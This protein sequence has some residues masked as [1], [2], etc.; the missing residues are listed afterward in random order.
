MDLE[1]VPG[2]TFFFHYTKW[3]AALEIIVSRSLRL[4]PYHRMGDPSESQQPARVPAGAFPFATRLSEIK[5]T[6]EAVTDQVDALY[7][8]SKLLSFTTDES[9]SSCCCQSQA[10]T[11]EVSEAWTKGWARPAMWQHYAASHRGVCCVFTRERLC[12]VGLEQLREDCPDAWAA[13]VEYLPPSHMHHG[14]GTIDVRCGQSAQ[15][16]VQQ[17]FAEYRDRFFTKIDDWEHEHE[18]RFL[19][20]STEDGYAFIDYRDSLQA[21][22]VGCAFPDEHGK[23]LQ[24]LAEANDFA[25]QQILWRFGRPTLEDP[26]WTMPKEKLAQNRA[27][28]DAE[29]GD[30]PAHDLHSGHVSPEPL[31]MTVVK[32]TESATMP[33]KESTGRML[34]WCP[35]RRRTAEDEPA[36]QDLSAEW[37]KATG[38]LNE[39]G[40]CELVRL[41]ERADDEELSRGNQLDTKTGTFGAIGGLLLT[42]TIALAKPTFSDKLGAVGAPTARIA[43][44]AAGVLLLATALTAL[45][46]V[47]KPKPYVALQ[48]DE[49]DDFL[50]PDKQTTSREEIQR[51]WLQTLAVRV[52]NNRSVNDRK[53]VAIKRLAWVITGGILCLCLT[54][55]VL[56][57]RSWHGL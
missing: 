45:H 49:L 8:N 42:A 6:P 27:A 28:V 10:T 32:Q 51:A 20:P 13:P 33:R 29:Y 2:G 52:R 46:G 41:A 25:V 31:D 48:T 39:C 12:E 15:A 50:G 37:S 19:L 40:I 26:R 17:H 7:A 16:L 55:F 4:S 22:I 21:V 24:A 34:R 3:E 43:L 38:E 9:V 44:I 36:P 54:A 1:H 53:V 30:D 35:G 57:I 23:C 56:T 5:P 47:V 18:F 14:S 11:D